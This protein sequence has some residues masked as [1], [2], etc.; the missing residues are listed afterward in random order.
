MKKFVSHSALLF[1]VLMLAGASASRGQDFFRDIGTSRSS[2]GIGPVTPSDYTYE[3]ASPSGLR[4]L[5]PGQDLSVAEQTEE[6]DKYNFALG[7]FRFGIALGVGVEFNDNINL[8]D[9]NRESD[10]I[11]R[12]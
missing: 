7:N 1:A 6:T 11:F 5:R 2:G 8:S 10:F 12:P 3:D 4:S 9:H